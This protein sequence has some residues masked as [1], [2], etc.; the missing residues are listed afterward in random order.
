MGIKA[1]LTRD[2]ATENL[3]QLAVYERTGGYSGFKKALE[4]QP[5]ALVDLV[6]ASGL[7]GRGGAGFA[8]GNKWS[9]LP[10]GMYPR[11]LVWNAV[12]SESGCV[13]YSY[14]IVESP[15]Q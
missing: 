2:F 8:T 1:V 4:M 11:Y 10:K 12:E 7:R 9:F 6:K 3:E 13:E 14:M 15:P 5:D